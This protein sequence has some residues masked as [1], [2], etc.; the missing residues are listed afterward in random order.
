[1]LSAP[2]Y[3]LDIIYESLLLGDG[4]HYEGRESYWTVNKK[5]ADDVSELCVLLGKSV[6]INKREP[7]EHLLPH[8]EM[9]KTFNTQYAVNNR[10]RITQELR[11][12]DSNFKC[13]NKEE[14]EGKTYCVT[15]EAGALV[16]KRNGKVSICGNCYGLA[17]D[18]VLLKDK[19][20]NG[21]FESASWETDVDFDGDGIA[22]WM[23]VV[24][25]FKR[26][27]WEWGGDW[28]FLDKPH[29]QKT[30]GYSIMDLQKLFNTKK[31]IAN[32][33]YLAIS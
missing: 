13:I 15:T 27:G 25:I 9:L 16:V 11:N 33:N 3:L 19:D 2:K 12:G 32:T 20:K 28:R 26:Y 17:I 5:L 18:I 29:F 14:Y 30:F 8:G 7:K 4:T 22:D 1:L 21:S 24:A 23:E 10:N 31:F 6:S